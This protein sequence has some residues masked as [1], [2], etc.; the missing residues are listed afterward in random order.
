MNKPAVRRH[1][2][3]VLAGLARV[4]EFLAERGERLSD[5]ADALF[6]DTLEDEFTAAL[7]LLR[8]RSSGD[9]RADPRPAKFPAAAP[10]VALPSP[11]G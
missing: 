5:E 9:Y 4:P 8:R 11:P 1:V 2:R 7:A 3:G 10:P 6:L